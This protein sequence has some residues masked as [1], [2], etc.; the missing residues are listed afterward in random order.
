M[1]KSFIGCEV[2]CVM[3]IMLS[4]CGNRIP[5]MDETTQKMV[6]EYAAATVRKYNKNHAS[7]LL[8]QAI[9]QENLGREAKLTAAFDRD[10]DETESTQEKTEQNNEFI[11]NTNQIT[12]KDAIALEEIE[13]TYNG[14]DVTTEYPMDAENIYFSLRATE[15]NCLLV[16]KFDVIN[17]SQA[18]RT[19]NMSESGIR[20]KIEVNGK[21]RNALT[22]ML[23]NDLSGFNGTIAAGAQE[24]MVLVC[25]IPKKDAQTLGRITVNVINEDQI[26]TVLLDESEHE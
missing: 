14:Y 6:V 12:L 13:V 23:L 19:L 5:Q 11:D 10:A 15:N 9:L 3:L 8:E 22:T 25:E 24:Q 18:D 20:Y 21:K 1:R 16:L 26:F 2:L 7:H 17:Q 4:G